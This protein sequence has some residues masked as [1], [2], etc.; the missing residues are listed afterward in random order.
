MT[1]STAPL[2]IQ[3]GA[4][5]G[6]ELKTQTSKNAA[7]P[8]IIA[9]LL[10]AEPVVLHGIPRLSDVETLL[11][12]MGGCGAEHSWSGPDTLTI[13]TPSI[14]STCPSP[15]M[16]GRMRASFIIFGALVGRAGEAEMGLPGGCA[17][18]D[19]PVD[20][21]LK[22][23]R[24]MGIEIEEHGSLY[25]AHRN[26][27]PEGR[28]V[29]D[30]LTVGGTHNAILA[31]VLGDKEVHLENASIDTD[32]VDL[33]NFLN[34][35]GAKIS[36]GGTNSL[37]IQGVSALRGGEYR[38]I[39]DRI[40]AGTFM[41]AAV[42]TRS[43]ITFTDLK[44]SHLH[45]VV[46]K[47]REVGAVV[48]EH[49]EDA[50]T[51]DATEGKLHAVEVVAQSFPGFPTDLQQQMGAMLSTIPGVSH[52]VD[53]IYGHR[54]SHVS[55]L[56]R[57]GAEIQI[58]PPSQEKHATQVI[59]GVPRLQGCEV[60]AQDLR[61]G[62]ALVIAGLAAEGET[63]IYDGLKYINRGYEDMAKTLHGLGAQVSPKSL[64][65]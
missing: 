4:T 46:S 12:I 27:S 31:A 19:R 62:A 34:S 37:T 28:A 40:Y 1:N 35:I 58:L 18:G 42:A 22:A 55:E 11:E 33:I 17:F 23:F 2:H 52:V 64:R 6:G 61:G 36:G 9:C 25:R 38:V 32:V 13:C 53:P 39:P 59:R 24:A 10:S 50:I 51:V 3:G 16:I 15:E 54:V 14:S 29:F 21:H 7:L 47:L 43:K 49:G 44:L 63:V 30:V 48:T 20:Q 56:R 57:M 65:I 26:G 8:I 45:A 60:A 5:L 41:I